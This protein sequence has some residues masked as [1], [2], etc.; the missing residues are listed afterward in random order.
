M[1]PSALIADATALIADLRRLELRIATA[2]SCSGGLL[3][4]L[5]TE[6]AGASDVLE[7]G[8]VT[9]SNAAK[10]ELLAVAAHVLEAHGAVSAEVAARMAS[11]AVAASHAD[12]GVG[13]TG[14]A[15]PGGG[16]PAKPVGL[17]HIAV[18][19]RGQAALHRECRFGDVGRTQIRLAA[20]GA[21][22]DLIRQ[23]IA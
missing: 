8:F 3:A 13:I 18:V 1:F 23:A 17:V 22:L 9:Y 7:R 19:R 4:G 21:A 5:L 2:E 20:I 6:I 12:L 10:I 16:T 11:G 15:G 14:L